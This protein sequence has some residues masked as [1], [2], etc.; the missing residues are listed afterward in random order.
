MRTRKRDTAPPTSSLPI[1]EVPVSKG[2]SPTEYIPSASAILPDSRPADV[3]D[4]LVLP[5]DSQA[6]V[7]GT[8]ALEAEAVPSSES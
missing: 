6:A 4:T 1:V 3:T 7:P 8:L 2:P 5:E